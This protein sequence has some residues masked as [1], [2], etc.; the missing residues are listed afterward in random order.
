MTTNGTTHRYALSLDV[1]QLAA[2]PQSAGD[3]P[4]LRRFNSDRRPVFFTTS[5]SE[6]V[7]SSRGSVLGLDLAI[8]RDVIGLFFVLTM[9]P[10]NNQQ[11]RD[12]TRQLLT[13]HRK[14]I[15]KWAKAL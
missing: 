8:V 3:C 14:E 1:A 11:S 10:S 6:A 15:S 4:C 2:P 9:E 7:S 13:L 5:G 12:S